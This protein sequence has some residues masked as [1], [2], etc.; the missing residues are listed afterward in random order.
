MPG[1]PAESPGEFVHR[2]MREEQAKK[3]RRRKR[4][5]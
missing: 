4:C 3:A 2:R 5:G 1:T